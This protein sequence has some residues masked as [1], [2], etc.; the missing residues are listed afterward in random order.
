VILMTRN[1]QP[2][3]LHGWDDW[4]DAISPYLITLGLLLIALLLLGEVL[5]IRPAA[6]QTPCGDHAE[7]TER[8]ATVHREKPQAIG[9][10]TDGRLLEVFLSRL[11]ALGQF[12]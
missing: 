12:S 4:V 11:A 6:A 1:K 2:R 9:L 3:M 5:S 10:S 7:L 8:L